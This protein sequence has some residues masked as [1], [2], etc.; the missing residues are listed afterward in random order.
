MFCIKIPVVRQAFLE[1][2][3][4]VHRWV[5]NMRSGHLIDLKIDINP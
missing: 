4:K 2:T 5:F 1:T 3:L